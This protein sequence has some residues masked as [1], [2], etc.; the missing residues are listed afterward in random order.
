MHIAPVSFRSSLQAYQAQ[1]D[2]LLQGWNTED[3]DATRLAVHKHPK[4]LRSDVPWLPEL[5]P[6]SDVS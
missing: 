3:R 1:A 6:T 5:K 2:E 4:F